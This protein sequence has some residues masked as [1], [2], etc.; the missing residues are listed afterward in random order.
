[1]YI[2]TLYF[3]SSYDE[4]QI[5]ALPILP[6]YQASRKSCYVCFGSLSTKQKINDKVVSLDSKWGQSVKKSRNVGRIIDSA[7]IAVSK[8]QIFHKCYLMCN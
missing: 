5:P 4:A 3:L 7:R 2:S 1:M 6:D 8:M